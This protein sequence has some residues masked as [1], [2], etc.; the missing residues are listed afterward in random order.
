MI[1]WSLWIG[2]SKRKK[3]HP[4][5][6]VSPCLFREF[7][8][9]TDIC[10]HL[11]WTASTKCLSLLNNEKVIIGFYFERIV[12]YRYSIELLNQL[13]KLNKY[14]ARTC[15][16]SFFYDIRSVGYLLFSDTASGYIHGLN[17]I[18]CLTSNLTAQS[19]VCYYLLRTHPISCPSCMHAHA[20]RGFLLFWISEISTHK[21]YI[22]LA[23]L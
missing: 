21:L 2:F 13:E 10:L 23:V 3:Y 12:A 20:T 17:L 4:A 6:R 7:Y 5:K 19:R 11:S 22:S 18:Y 8:Q 14:N 9:Q 1:S 15:Y 16:P